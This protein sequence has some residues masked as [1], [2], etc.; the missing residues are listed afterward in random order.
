LSFAHFS[1]PECGE[2]QRLIARGSP[3]TDLIALPVKDPFHLHAR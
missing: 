2:R 1:V 3:I